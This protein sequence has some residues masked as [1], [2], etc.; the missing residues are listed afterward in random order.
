MILVLKA[1][2]T[3]WSLLG[4]VEVQNR[5]LKTRIT[6][7]SDNAVIS[8][9]VEG[10]NFHLLLF[11]LGY[12]QVIASWSGLLIRG[13]VT[14]GDIVH[15]DSIV[16]GP[17]LNRAYELESQQAIYPRIILDPDIGDGFGKLPPFMAKK[18]A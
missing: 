15:D 17:A 7:F 10:P 9:P 4:N 13:A 5:G 8:E 1:A 3:G 18:V 11:R 14:I 12:M 6:T 16:F 2:V